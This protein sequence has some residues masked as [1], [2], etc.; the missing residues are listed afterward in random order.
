MKPFACP[1]SSD[2]CGSS[3]SQLIMHPTKRNFLK[4]QIEND[5]YVDGKTCY[6]EVQVPDADLNREAYRYFWDI[7]IIEQKNVEIYISNGRSID[8]ANNTKTANDTV[9]Y[10]F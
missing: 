8:S 9:G 7:E 3:T 6:F 2:Y 10:R 4:L 5:L 1:Y